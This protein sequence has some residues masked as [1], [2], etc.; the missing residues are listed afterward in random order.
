[1]RRAIHRL[2]KR[3]TAVGY[4]KHD[5][6]LKGYLVAAVLYGFAIESLVVREQ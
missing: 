6:I 1:M 5:I 4:D 3:I 2:T